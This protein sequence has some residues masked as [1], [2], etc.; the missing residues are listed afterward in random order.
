MVRRE[1]SFGKREG[2][3]QRWLGYGEKV[4]C[5]QEIRKEMWGVEEYWWG[6]DIVKNRWNFS[7]N[8]KDQK[9]N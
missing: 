6:E 4:K 9:E 7:L 3:E 2:K 1:Q 8:V 5:V